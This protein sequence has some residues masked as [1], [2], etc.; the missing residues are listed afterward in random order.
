M[1][2]ATPIV[3]VIARYDFVEDANAD[4][5]KASRFFVENEVNFY[6]AALLTT[7]A[8]VQLQISEWE[9]RLP[10]DAPAFIRWA[11]ADLIGSPVAARRHGAIPP[12]TATSGLTRHDLERVGL[13][14]GP[15]SSVL[16]VGAQ[17]GNP[18]AFAACFARASRIAQR[19]VAVDSTGAYPALGP[20]LREML[21]AG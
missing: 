20:A 18:E 3:L 8:W 5:E 4:L 10:S 6:D 1:T 7:D 9:A 17:T 16:V 13:S 12:D 14:M 21:T 11:L 15:V 2:S 19:E